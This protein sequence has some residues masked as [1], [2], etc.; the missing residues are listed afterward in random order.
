MIKRTAL[1]GVR[2]TAIFALAAA[3]IQC[4]S[5]GSEEATE[6]S[7]SA[8]TSGDIATCN[9]S[10]LHVIIGTTNNDVLTGTSAADCIVGLG[11]QDTINGAGGDDIVLGGDGDD[12][13]TGGPGNDRLFGG[14]GQDKIY[15][16]DGN[17]TLQGDAG[18]DQLFGEA[19]NDTLDDCTN[20][21]RFSGGLGTNS[22]RGDSRDSSFA[23]C[24]SISSCS[25]KAAQ[26]DQA[27]TAPSDLS[28]GLYGRP[29]L[30]AQTYTAGVTGTLQGVAIDVTRTGTNIARIQI[31]A[32]S[33]GVPNNVV[34]GQARASGPGDLSLNTVIPFSTPIPQLAGQQYA[35]IVDYPDAP[36]FV[37]NQ[38]PQGDWIGA[39]GNAYPAGTMVD[40]WD[41]GATWR[42]RQ[43]EGFDL[44]FKTF[45]IPN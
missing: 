25:A 5:A 36:P 21:N 1:T 43:A 14:T 4:S 32:V 7:E 22:C 2:Y 44:H 13:I 42:S 35:I 30:T 31:E 40:S 10:G 38:R 18:D 20:H 9:A 39:T 24:A 27:F 34:L 45:V 12:T 33:G 11:G 29:V 23:N 28:A 16:G 6:T 17:D 8:L 19:G 26:I 41:N 15:G 37:D 3:S